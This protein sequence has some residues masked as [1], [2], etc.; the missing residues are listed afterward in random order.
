MSI[1][2]HMQIKNIKSD[3]SVFKPITSVSNVTQ[4]MKRKLKWATFSTLVSR[5]L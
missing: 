2:V 4:I 1:S 5:I 3:L